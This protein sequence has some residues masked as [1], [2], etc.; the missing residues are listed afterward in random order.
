MEKKTLSDAIKYKS[1]SELIKVLRQKHGLTQIDVAE[2]LGYSNAQSVSNWERGIQ[3]PPIDFVPK[4]CKILKISKEEYKEVLIKAYKEK[5]ES[6]L[7]L[8]S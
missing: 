3:T 6:Y 7:K 1:V 4:L 2:R 8:Y 5:T